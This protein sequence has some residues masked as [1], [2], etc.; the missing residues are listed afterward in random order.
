METKSYIIIITIGILFGIYL[1][2][3]GA[4]SPSDS[5]F[6]RFLTN[7]SFLPI[8][9]LGIGVFI[10]IAIWD[11]SLKEQ[12]SESELKIVDRIFIDMAKIFDE[13]YT[14]APNFVNSL[15]LPWRRIHLNFDAS[16]LSTGDDWSVVNYLSLRIFQ[17]WED[18]LTINNVDPTGSESWINIF[19]PYASSKYLFQIWETTKVNFEPTTR[20]FGDLMFKNC[21]NN[22]PNNLEEI[23]S[24]NS[25]I[26]NSEEYKNTV[27]LRKKLYD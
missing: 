19:I 15:F 22:P 21:L 27:K 7:A 25:K 4:K 18:F 20:L 9:F 11:R 3:L 23:Y 5:T 10:S 14:Q 13:Y 16:Y 26:M 17:A 2:Y 8:F 6:S 1:M 12:K 24:L